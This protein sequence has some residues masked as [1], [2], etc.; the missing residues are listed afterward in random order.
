MTLVG[1]IASSTFLTIS[2]TKIK[3]LN[4]YKI[5]KFDGFFS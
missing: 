3:Y 4:K 1:S 2:S 5:S